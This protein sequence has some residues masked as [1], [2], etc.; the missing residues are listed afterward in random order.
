M[1]LKL[2]KPTE[3]KIKKKKDSVL[4]KTNNNSHHL[5][6]INWLQMSTLKVH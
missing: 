6:N 2:I 4:L 1:L 3:N 5:R